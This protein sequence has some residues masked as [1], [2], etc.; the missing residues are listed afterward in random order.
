M[1]WGNRMKRKFLSEGVELELVTLLRLVVG[2]L[3]LLPELVRGGLFHTLS[4]V[5]MNERLI[6]LGFTNVPHLLL[7]MQ[8]I[9]LLRKWGGGGNTV[10]QVVCVT[11]FDEVVTPMWLERAQARLEKHVESTE[12]LRVLREQVEALDT[13]KAAAPVVGLKSLDEIAIMVVELERLQKTVVEQ[14]ARIAS[15]ESELAA[16]TSI[17]PDAALA[18]AIKRARE[19]TN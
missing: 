18:A 12:S 6:A 19:R 2:K 16:R 11:F 9:G 7:L 13:A 10:W 17:D 14:T 5:S 8:E 4:K 3:N 1:V 15:L